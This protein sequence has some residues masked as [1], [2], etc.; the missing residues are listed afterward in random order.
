MAVRAV[1]VPLDGTTMLALP[2]SSSSSSSSSSLLPL[3]PLQ[4]AAAAVVRDRVLR[5]PRG[6]LLHRFRKQPRRSGV[7]RASGTESESAGGSGMVDANM[8]ILRKR[9]QSLRTQET[10]Y[11]MPKE[12]MDWERN[13]YASYR[14]DICL[15]LS[16]IES[17]LLIMRPS[18]ALSIVSMS[19][20]VLPVASLLFLTA[21]GTQIWT[22]NCALLD[23][24]PSSH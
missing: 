10:F 24:I 9:I 1:T 17:Q 3:L 2:S 8:M 14:A 22:L 13:A 20:A 15:L 12:W 4:S 19:L 11:D 6:S 18:I 23:L 5:V 7:V 21:L 16:M